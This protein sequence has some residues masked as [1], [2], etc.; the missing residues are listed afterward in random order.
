[1]PFLPKTNIAASFLT[2]ASMST[3]ESLPLIDLTSKNQNLVNILKLQRGIRKW[4]A[5]R[6]LAPG[7]NSAFARGVPYVSFFHTTNA[8]YQG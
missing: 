2:P 6:L 3:Q 4:G 5:F 7:I 1:L 8:L